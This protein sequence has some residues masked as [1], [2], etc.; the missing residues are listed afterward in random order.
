MNTS[1]GQE[2]VAIGDGE[3]TLN[4]D[5]F[6]MNLSGEYN[7]SWTQ[8]IVLQS[9]LGEAR[10]ISS[11]AFPCTEWIDLYYDQLRQYRRPCFDS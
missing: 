2:S 11:L 7:Y 3:E 8:Q 10:A 6:P 5:M 1:F 9:E 4:G